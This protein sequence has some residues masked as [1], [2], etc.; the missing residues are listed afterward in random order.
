MGTAGGGP[1]ET[2]K[3]LP[4]FFDA[5]G[6]AVTQHEAVS[7]DGT[8]IPY[9]QVARDDLA[10]DGSNPTLLTGYGGFQLARRPVYDPTIGRRLAGEGGSVR[11]RQYPRR[12]RVRP[13]VAPRRAE[14]Q[15]PQGVRGLHRRR[16]GPDPP[17]GD[18]DP[19]S[20]APPGGA[21][22]DC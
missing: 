3:R 7:K 13:E 1:P 22:A 15:P 19:R 14:G 10:L 16:R 5:K 21:T 2:L 20:W 11:P 8:R 18:L 12:R 4:A 17:Q 6:L 9:F